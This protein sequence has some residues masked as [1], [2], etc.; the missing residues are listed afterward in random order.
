MKRR[1]RPWRL[2]IVLAVIV[3]GVV[4]VPSASSAGPRQESDPADGD[5]PDQNAGGRLAISIQVDRADEADVEDAFSQIRENVEAEQAQLN[6]A[7]QAVQTADASV[8]AAE[9]KVAALQAQI[10][11]LVGQSDDVVVRT[12]VNPPSEAAIES[13]TAESVSDA[14]IKHALLDM[15]ANADAAVLDKLHGLEADLEEQRETEDAARA[16]AAEKRE[17]AERALSDLE[18][19]AS[20]QVTF[21]REIERRLERNLGEIEALK[22][23]DPE[24][25]AQMQATIDQLSS[26]LAAARERLARDDRLKELDIDLPTVEGPSE[27]DIDALEGNILSVSCPSGGD[28]E[29]HKDIADH[30]RDLLNL[31]FQKGL[32]LCGNGYRDISQQIA[33]RKANCGGNV[34]TTPASACSPPTARPGQSMHERGLAIDFTCG[35]YGAVGRGDPCDIFLRANAPDFGLYNL[36]SEPWHYSSDGT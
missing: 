1:R 18:E 31:S 21:A 16:D 14:T 34:W 32:S 4:L 10:D 13:F 20:Q 3:S 24:L 30:T 8:T 35:G 25:A 7:E 6:G 9:Q 12:F 28:I 22:D 11:E 23:L 2:R 17:D 15:R 19:A 26:D 5:E 33:L 29:V 36:P 27:I